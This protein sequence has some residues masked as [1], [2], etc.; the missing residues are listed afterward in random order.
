MPSCRPD[1]SSFFL[2]SSQTR[3]RKPPSRITSSAA[4][5]EFHMTAGHGTYGPAAYKN[6]DNGDSPA[7]EQ[8]T[9]TTCKEP[10]SDSCAERVEGDRLSGCIRYWAAVGVGKA[11]ISTTEA[12]CRSLVELDRLL[13]SVES[14]SVKYGQDLFPLVSLCDVV[15]RGVLLCCEESGGSAMGRYVKSLLTLRGHVERAKEVAAPLCGKGRMAKLSR[16]KHLRR[17]CEAVLESVSK[18]AAHHKPELATTEES[19]V[20]E[21]ESVCLIFLG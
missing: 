11:G 19:Y 16:R 20:S 21:R 14:G 15:A 17:N 10:M 2:V 1:L 18:F 12:L 3:L 5:L 7:A 4:G 9:Q 13:C 8:Q 6:V